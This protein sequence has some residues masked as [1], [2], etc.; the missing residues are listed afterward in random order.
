M[1]KTHQLWE[2]GA[3]RLWPDT[4]AVELLVRVRDTGT[5]IAL[6]PAGPRGA[7]LH[8]RINSCCPEESFWKMTDRVC[9]PNGF[10]LSMTPAASQGGW[11]TFRPRFPTAPSPAHSG[12][13]KL[14]LCGTW[15]LHGALCW[16]TLPPRFLW[17]KIAQVLK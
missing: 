3:L 10:S 9:L 13:R 11:G 5:S 6:K 8:S 2:Q 1:V 16:N 14:C 7:R 4:L 12:P 15:I 17:V